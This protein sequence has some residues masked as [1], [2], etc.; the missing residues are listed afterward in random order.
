MDKKIYTPDK[1]HSCNYWTLHEVVFV[2]SGANFICSSCNNSIFMSGTERKIRKHV[3]DV[4]KI[5]PGLASINPDLL[6]LKKPGDRVAVSPK[7]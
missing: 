2:P 7:D 1:C 5:F 6:N 3:A 4:K